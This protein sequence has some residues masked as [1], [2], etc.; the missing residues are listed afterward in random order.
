MLKWKNKQWVE[1]DEGFSFLFTGRYT[2][3]YI[4]GDRNLSLLI[5]DSMSNDNYG[6][7]IKSGS[8]NKWDNNQTILLNEKDVILRNISE[9]LEFQNI[10]LIIED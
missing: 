7:I 8:M 6:I 5:E 1:S 3:E 10:N 2:A 9:A 4:E